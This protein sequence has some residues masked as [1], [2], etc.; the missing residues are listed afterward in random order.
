MPTALHV[1]VDKDSVVFL[2]TLTHGLWVSQDVGGSWSAACD[3]STQTQAFSV[4]AVAACPNFSNDYEVW[5]GRSDGLRLSFD[6]GTTCAPDFPYSSV[7]FIAFSPGYHRGGDCD[8]FVGT[9]TGLYLRTCNPGPPPE[10]VTP[11]AVTVSTVAIGPKEPGVWAVDGGGLLRNT[12]GHVQLQYN[13]SGAFNNTTPNIAAICLDPVFDASK[14]SEC[15]NDA[16]TLF[17]AEKT[18]GVFKSTDN[19]NSWT[20]VDYNSTWPAGVMVNDLAIS[21]K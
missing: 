17:V 1:A 18:L 15:G 11:P 8:A 16:Q 7:Q 4:G 3:G 9:N 10:P 5:E 20:K 19:G 6:G 13:G 21:P 12:I 2:G 14:T